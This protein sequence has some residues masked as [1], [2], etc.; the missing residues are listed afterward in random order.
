MGRSW[1]RGAG[2]DDAGVVFLE[3]SLWLDRSADIG[4]ADEGDAFLLHQLDAAEDDLLLVELHVRNAIHEQAAGAVG[5]LVN[6][7]EVAGTV[8]LRGGGEAGGAGAD[9]GDFFPGARFWRLRVDPAFLPA[10]VG[11]GALNVLDRDR[12]VVDAEH[13]GALARRGTHAAGELGEIIGFVQAVERLVPE[14]AVNQ[15]VP[16]GD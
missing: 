12:R 2:A 16:L 8:E 14:P 13:A 10:A 11:N 7:H 5:P 6:R 4:V 9:H 1:L 15:I 3:K